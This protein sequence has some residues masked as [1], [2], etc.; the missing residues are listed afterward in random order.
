MIAVLL[1]LALIGGWQLY[2][3]FGDVS[4]LL[5]PAP[6]E[7]V[8]ALWHER[9]LLWSNFTVT[10][11]EM[12]LGLGCALA[13]AL[14]CALAI[15]LSATLRRAVTPLLIASQT[16]PIVILAPLLVVWFGFD[17]TP[18]LMIVAIVTFFP[19]V[20]NTLDGLAGVDPSLRKLMTT[21]GASRWQLLR[22]VEA[23]TAL[24]GL[25]SG[26][27]IAVA[28]AAIGAVLAEQA[29][30]TSGLGNLIIHASDQLETPTAYAAVVVLAVFSVLLFGALALAER[31]IAPWADR[32]RSEGATV[33]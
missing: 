21:L 8:Q 13:A 2:A 16:V 1:G 20:V 12:A 4:R 28:V 27:K 31:R 26:G 29:G 30:S 22:H 19:I 32:S 23:P 14:L 5:L 11:E 3:T 7:V 10:A 9:S 6:S 33:P 17:I 24:P 15:H 25:L 18:K